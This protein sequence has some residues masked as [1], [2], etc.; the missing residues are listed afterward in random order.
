[1]I[2]RLALLLCFLSS[3]TLRAADPT[4]APVA[5][6]VSVPGTIEAFWS[7]DLSAKVSGYVSDVKA[8]IG[9]HVT[10]GQL[11]AVISE[12]ELQASLAQ[13]KAT[14]QSRRQ[15]LR[16]ADATITQAKQSVEVAKKQLVGQGAEAS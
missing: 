11:L 14:L 3:T 12:P 9:D 4:S 1:M 16:A 13:A 2:R 15:M 10:R 7:V 5:Q 8:D 6:S